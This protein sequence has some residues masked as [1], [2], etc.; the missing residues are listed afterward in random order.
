M[1]LQ[2]L[3]SKNFPLS[4]CFLNVFIESIQLKFSAHLSF[5][6]VECMGAFLQF[7]VFSLVSSLRD[8]IR[9]GIV[10]Q[11]KF[12]RPSYVITTHLQPTSNLQCAARVYCLVQSRRLST[13]TPIFHYRNTARILYDPG[14]ERRK[15]RNFQ[16]THYRRKSRYTLPP[17]VTQFVWTLFIRRVCEAKI[18]EMLSV[19]NQHG[20]QK[21]FLKMQ[22]RF[23]A[24]GH[25]DSNTFIDRFDLYYHCKGIRLRQRPDLSTISPRVKAGV[26][27]GFKVRCATE[28][29]QKREVISRFSR[30]SSLLLYV[31][32]LSCFSQGNR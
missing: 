7:E 29:Y 23:S 15:S 11:R 24:R 13:V 25:Q 4:S 31:P 17:F 14:K 20:Q 6:S 32:S 18:L 1:C 19:S 8:K 16:L 12:T 30:Y 21:L 3:G 9:H 22:F 5:A 2:L 10:S 28:S 27:L 26:V